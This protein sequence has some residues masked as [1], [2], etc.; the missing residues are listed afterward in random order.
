MSLFVELDLPASAFALEATLAAL[1]DAVVEVERV[2]ASEKLLTPYFWVANVSGEA[3][4]AATEADPSVRD[5]R[6]LDVFEE[7]TLYRAEWTENIESVVAA[8]TRVGA[9]ILD[10]TGQGDGWD[11]QL[12]FDDRDQLT[13][14]QSYCAANDVTFQIKRLYEVSHAHT[15]RQY[16]LTEKQHEALVRAWHAGFFESPAEST[17]SEIAADLGIS[18]Q[19]LSQRMRKGY[20]GLV[21]NTLVTEPPAAD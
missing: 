4:E 14:F 13:A 15:G 16:G 11:V 5:C 20:D 1:P 10:A 9:V 21:A 19:A 17:L 6:R 3:F 7:A 18:Q 2:V 8:Y 12:R